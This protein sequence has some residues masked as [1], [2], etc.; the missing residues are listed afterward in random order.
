MHQTHLMYQALQIN[1]AHFQCVE[2]T[3]ISLQLA[4]SPTTMEHTAEYRC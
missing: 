1:L 4:K 3:Y 2:S